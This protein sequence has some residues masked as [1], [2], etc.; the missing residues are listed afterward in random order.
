M[1]DLGGYPP[2]DWMIPCVQHADNPDDIRNVDSDSQTC[3]P[4][5]CGE[6]VKLSKFM[7][8]MPPIPHDIYPIRQLC[9]PLSIE[10][11]WWQQPKSQAPKEN[12]TRPTSCPQPT[13]SL[14]KLT[15][16]YA[17]SEVHP[18]DPSS[19]AQLVDLAN[20]RVAHRQLRG[21]PVL[22]QGEEVL[23]PGQ[24]DGQGRTQWDGAQGVRQSQR[25]G[26]R[27]MQR[28]VPARCRLSAI[29]TRTRN[30][31]A[32]SRSRRMNVQLGFLKNKGYRFQTG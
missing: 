28:A 26:Q 31:I 11:A 15:E 8:C 12:N 7:V 25:W 24:G 14:A 21:D 18:V 2:L 1:R 10:K 30:V 27:S 16:A 19:R 9:K 5:M 32:R 6:A 20:E 22:D 3:V 23:Q 17:E 13:V 29:R 4:G